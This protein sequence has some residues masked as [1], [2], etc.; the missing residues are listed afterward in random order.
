[1]SG[2][3]RVTPS[4]RLTNVQ[5]LEAVARFAVTGNPRHLPRELRHEADGIRA[6]LMREALAGELNAPPWPASAA[7]PHPGPGAPFADEVRAV[8]GDR[9]DEDSGMTAG[10]AP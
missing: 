2:K 6:L 4:R 3:N 10:D 7:R 5:V 1:M 9:A 8:L